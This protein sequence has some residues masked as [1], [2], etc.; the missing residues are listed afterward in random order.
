MTL[1]KLYSSY[2]V[3]YFTVYDFNVKTL[4][5][6]ENTTYLEELHRVAKNVKKLQE[7][8]INDSG[9]ICG[10]TPK[11][12]MFSNYFVLSYKEP[13]NR[14]NF[15]INIYK[16]IKQY[17]L[18]MQYQ[19]AEND[20]WINGALAFGQ[21]Y[22]HGDINIGPAMV[23]A[24]ETLKRQ[25]SYKRGPWIYLHE[26]IESAD[27]ENYIDWMRLCFLE[28]K[29]RLNNIEKVIKCSVSKKFIGYDKK[30]T[31]IQNYFEDTRRRLETKG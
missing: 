28:D 3:C 20:I 18:E 17:L 27:D 1:S 6:V 26:S 30:I 31:E 10:N 9:K 19:L 14:N 23:Y 11:I 2:Y 15:N 5:N 16:A 7:K 12:S 22:C 24:V 4:E 29:N 13:Q 8:Y 25:S 21:F